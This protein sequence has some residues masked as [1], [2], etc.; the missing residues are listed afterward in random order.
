MSKSALYGT[1]FSLYSLTADPAVR[2]DNLR[3][4]VGGG[5]GFSFLSGVVS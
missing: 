2:N 3:G 4:G 1:M 5:G